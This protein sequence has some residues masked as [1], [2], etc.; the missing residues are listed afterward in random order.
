MKS[1]LHRVMR[2]RVG[3]GKVFAY[4]ISIVL[5]ALVSL[6]SIPAMVSASGAAAWGAIAAG[7]SIGVVAAVAISYGWSLSG[8]AAV[9]RADES[10]RRRRFFE[11]VVLRLCIC[12]PVGGA[13]FGLSWAVGGDYA[14][15]A[16][17]GALSI[18]AVGLTANWYF[19]G[20]SQPYHLLLFETVPRAVFGVTGIVFM[21]TGSSARVGLQWQLAGVLSASLISSLWI[22]KPWHFRYK[23]SLRQISIM[24]LLRAQRYGVTSSLVNALY[25]SLPI[26]IVSVVAASSLPVFALVDKVQRLIFVAFTP[27]L[28]VLQGWVPRATGGGLV[29]RI[30]RCLVGALCVSIAIGGFVYL[31]APRLMHWMVDGEFALPPFITALLACLTGVGLTE[32]VLSM[33]CLAALKRLDI[34]ARATAVMSIVGLPLVTVG[35][36]YW[37][38][39]GALTGLLVGLSLRLVLEA[40]G[41][42][43]IVKRGIAE[44]VP[45]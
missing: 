3:F 41:L 38:A 20:R 30:E 44:P 2:A 23:Q 39:A 31:V 19:V 37:G 24:Q 9:A 40:L 43:R 29:R 16:G 28:S 18:A 10:H 4:S 25:F 13:A 6:A 12:V 35:A 32:A 15:F 22:L 7:Q 11:S 45:T 27:C 14:S 17:A 21:H 33:A 8:P 34:V 36:Y 42:S 1:P 26:V 5:L